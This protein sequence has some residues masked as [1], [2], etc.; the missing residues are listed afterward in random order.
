MNKNIWMKKTMLIVIFVFS[1]LLMLASPLLLNLF[2]NSSP[3]NLLFYE[4]VKCKIHSCEE[5][6]VDFHDFGGLETIPNFIGWATSVERATFNV[7]ELKNVQNLSRLVNL[8]SLTLLSGY[9]ITDISFLTNLNKLEHLELSNIKILDSS[10]IASLVSLA[11][12]NIGG[13]EISN[14]SFVLTMPNIKSLDVRGTNRN[15]SYD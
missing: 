5:L 15:S 11:H 8:E 2:K 3:K 4:V 10:P 7:S 12:L 6:Y 1:V 13:A 14:L 9:H